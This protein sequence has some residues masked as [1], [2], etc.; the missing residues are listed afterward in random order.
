MSGEAIA[1]IEGRIRELDALLENAFPDAPRNSPLSVGKVGSKNNFGALLGQ[2]TNLQPSVGPGALSMNKMGSIGGG[3]LAPFVVEANLVRG[4]VPAEAIPVDPD[5][6]K[7]RERYLPMIRE[8]SALTGVPEALI[9]AVIQAESSY[10]PETRSSAGAMGL[11]QLMPDNVKE[12]GVSDPYD[13]R[14]NILAGAR[15]L[16]QMIDRFG[17]LDKAL[18]GYNAGPGKVDRYGGVPPYRETQDYVQRITTMLR[19][20]GALPESGPMTPIV[21]LPPP[22]APSDSPSRMSGARE[23]FGAL[24]NNSDSRESAV[25][26][27]RRAE[28][29]DETRKSE[30]PDDKPTHESDPAP[31]AE[32]VAPV[33]VPSPP[34]TAPKT[35]PATA[36]GDERETRPAEA[37]GATAS[38][39][40]SGTAP[41][42]ASA[43]SGTPA[44]GMPT[45]GDSPPV[46]TPSPSP[47]PAPTPEATNEV[48]S[49]APVNAPQNAEASE[50][51]PVP[52]A[53]TET[54]STS[55]APTAK[56]SP[57]AGPTPPASTANA[58]AEATSETESDESVPA[59]AP[60]PGAEKTKKAE[61]AE[62]PSRAAETR[63]EAPTPTEA[64]RAA[65]A[66]RP[67]SEAAPTPA[68]AATPDPESV[69]QTALAER[70]AGM[71]QSARPGAKNELHV[72]LDP[73]NL[74]HVRVTVEGGMGDVAVRIV[75]ESRET[76]LMLQDQRGPLHEALRQSEVALGSFSAS[77]ADGGSSQSNS[78][79]PFASPNR[80]ALARAVPRI[81]NSVET[82]S[83]SSILRPLSLD[84]RA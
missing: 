68:A 45:T 58:S 1:R 82:S 27:T 28:R 13:P 35:P 80:F 79:S 47:T 60:T 38:P 81:E 63:L 8:A 62:A 17:T 72:R 6:R 29:I 11:M 10:K 16:R 9:S 30:K 49:V 21:N 43:A 65:E 20:A 56:P 22:N 23:D 66:V 7:R 74:G 46:P 26:S 15:H 84:T 42:T 37:V 31:A 73:P 14:Q 41:G 48:R 70:V 3:A 78:Q 57:A 52:V 18:A 50:A 69:T 75:A 59:V 54:P 55:A 76:M 71:A 2:K 36:S 5:E 32:T 19:K 53:P 4:D 44:T 64:P 25:A 24:L 83:G 34:P 67:A 40:E 77:L 39:T 51:A 12:L 61:A 33:V